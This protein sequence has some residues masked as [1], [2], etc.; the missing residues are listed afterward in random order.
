MKKA[1]TLLA[2]ILTL[3]MLC[4]CGGYVKSYSATMMLGVETDSGDLDG[5]VIARSDMPMPSNEQLEEA[6][7]AFRGRQ[8][9]TPPMVSAVKV[10]GKKLYDLARKG[11]EVDREPREINI[12]RLE[13]T[14]VD[15]PCCS[16]E[17]DCSK[18]TYVRTLAADIGKKL[19][20][21]AVLTA[22]RRTRSGM[23]DVKNAVTIEKLKSF[24]QDDLGDYL[25][26]ELA[27]TAGVLTR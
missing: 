15:M 23:F 3:V 6:F 19:G 25:A 10:D 5:K 2:L 11:V 4:S 26:S 12:S 16:F 17:L 14:G 27:R 22:L 21:G 9:Q 13:I 24:S 18:G 20:N 8:L 1:C 7:A